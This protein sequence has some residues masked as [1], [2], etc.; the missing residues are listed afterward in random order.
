MKT[1]KILTSLRAYVREDHHQGKTKF[2]ATCGSSA[3]VEALFDVGN[4]VTL[5][6][7]YCELCAKE[8]M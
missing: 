6:E 8:V 2:C 1:E 3:T 5:L 7:K 4:G